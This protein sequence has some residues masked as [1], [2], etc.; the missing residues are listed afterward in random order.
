M[1]NI[2]ETRRKKRKDVERRIRKKNQKKT[3]RIIKCD[4][5]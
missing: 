2:G 3:I 1:Q 4:Q 5:K